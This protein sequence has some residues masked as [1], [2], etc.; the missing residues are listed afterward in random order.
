MN[1]VHLLR[2]QT[3]V[4]LRHKKVLAEDHPA[5]QQATIAHVNPSPTEELGRQK[6]SRFY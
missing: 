2:T 3:S 5:Q 1:S 4:T 6:R